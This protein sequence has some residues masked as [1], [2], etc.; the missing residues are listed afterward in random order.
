MVLGMS[1]PIE[2]S[3][4]AEHGGFADELLAE[5]AVKY[6]SWQEFGAPDQLPHTL[7]GVALCQCLLMFRVL[8]IPADK[9]NWT[10]CPGRKAIMI[11]GQCCDSSRKK[12]W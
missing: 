1:I 6:C 3:A 11:F 4:G 5:G 7:P 12:S 10:Q 2:P 8:V 9:Q